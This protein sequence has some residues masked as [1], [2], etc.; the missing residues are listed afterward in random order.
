LPDT[1]IVYE[2]KDHISWITINRPEAGNTITLEL[3]QE[4]KDICSKINEDDDVY[5]VVIIG[6]GEKVFCGGME[7]ETSTNV[8]TAIASINKPV[9]AAV[10]GYAI[11]EGFELVLSC[12]IRIASDTASFKLPQIASG[13]IPMNGGTQRLPRLI[14]KG[15]AIELILTGETIDAAE[16]FNIG[17]VS[18]VVPYQELEKETESLARDM[19]SKAPISL[20]FVKEAVNKGMDFSL[21]QGLRLESD[22]YF[23][24][25]TT[26]DRT[27][28]IKAFLEKRR[29]EFNGE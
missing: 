20:Q 14:G 21:D 15:K 25:H 5:V 28:G 29:P 13:T 7:G 19:A 1:S 3:A 23:L 11:G 10:N 2:S 24:L 4:I 18:K 6:A 16:A 26:T 9:I 22:L 27:E 8:A 17:L 12:D